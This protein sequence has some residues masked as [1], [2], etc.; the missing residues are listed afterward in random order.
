MGLYVEMLSKKIEP[1]AFTFSAMLKN[2][3]I[4]TARGLHGQAIK[5][6]CE[7]NSYVRTGLIDV[8]A[9]GGEVE[10]AGQLFDKM[11]ERSLVS[12]TTMMTGLAK[13][14]DVDGA[15]AVFEGMGERDVV[16]WNVMIDAYVQH[17]RANEALVLFRE[18]LSG[19]VCPD[20][21]TLVAV[22][23]ACGQLGALES[24]R[25]VHGYMKNRRVRMNVH[26]GAALVD[27]YSKCGSWEDARLVFDEIKSKDIVV[28]N[29]MISGYAMNGLS[30][31]ALQLFSEM[32]QLSVHPTEITFIG[33]LSVCAHAGLVREGS[34]IF[35]SMRKEYGI[36]PRIEHYGCMINL[37]GRLGHLNEAFKLVKAMTMSI[38]TRPDQIIWRTLLDACRLHGDSDLGE[39]IIKFYT[40]QNPASSG[41]FILLSNIYAAKRNWNGAKRVRTMM[42]DTG[43]QKEPGCSS[44]E[45][46]NTVHE[47]LAGDAKH[48]KRKEIY[49]MLEEL[50]RCLRDYGND[51][52]QT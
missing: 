52:Q 33:L 41:A 10:L 37:L 22:F 14:G 6:G 28:W 32:R 30:R 3:P 40:D 26:V 27:M 2:S 47:F 16:C 50:N 1:N 18:M 36:E 13:N 45:V 39:D 49:L 21:V 31:E 15:R 43:I 38:A 11:P 42:K 51:A 19:D 35:R 8:Y 7:M 48:P 23:S 9:R 44:I 4:V 46:N 24:G 5:M 12:L 34:E 17:G 20:G 29:A 25:W